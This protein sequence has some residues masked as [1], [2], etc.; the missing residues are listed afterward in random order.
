VIILNEA[1]FEKRAKFLHDSTCP[2]PSHTE[3]VEALDQLSRPGDGPRLAEGLKAHHALLKRIYADVDCVEGKDDKDR[4]LNTI[5]TATLLYAVFAHGSL[6]AQDGRHS[7]RIDKALLKQTY[8][9]GGLA[10]RKRHLEHH[11]FTIGYFQGEEECASLSRASHLTVAYDEHADLVPALKL[12]A[13]RTESLEQS[14]PQPSGPQMSIF[15][16]A[17]YGAVMLG[18]PTARDHLDPLQTAILDT[19]DVYRQPWVDLVGRFCDDC[20]LQCS[21]FWAYGGSP[22]WGV[23]FSAKGKRPLA[24][25]TLGSGIVF[26]EFTL[27]VGAAAAI[28]RQRSS[29]T[30]RI[31]ERIEGFHC[32]K[33]PKACK[34]SNLIDVDGVSLCTGRAEAR[35]IYSYLRAPEDFASIQAMLDIICSDTHR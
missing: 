13:E 26:I 17:N 18:K 29:Y 5:Y 30:D 16:R 4:Y 33:C 27:P 12:F 19:I 14:H 23:S 31:R 34:G 35:R 21:G 2:Y 22:S 10:R 7:V 11:G 6:V 15:L 9:K 20:G 8:K 32:V 24:I 1:P 25:F 28:I 3:L